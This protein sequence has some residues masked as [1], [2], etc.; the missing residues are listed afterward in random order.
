MSDNSKVSQVDYD[1]MISDLVHQVDS[2]MEDIKN[3]VRSI[4][5]IIQERQTLE[6]DKR[7]S[8]DGPV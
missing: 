8:G 7:A 6:I 3:T 2:K 5:G 4:A 1:Q